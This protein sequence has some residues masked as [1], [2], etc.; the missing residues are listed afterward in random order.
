MQTESK[1][2]IEK[3]IDPCP[4]PDS[5]MRNE[6]V[7]THLLVDYLLFAKTS[8][9]SAKPTDTVEYQVLSVETGV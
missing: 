3:E 2:D 6:L 7:A 9:S 1:D 8:R 5:P 4:H